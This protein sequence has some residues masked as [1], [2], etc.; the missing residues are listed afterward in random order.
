MR[1]FQLN[2]RV[3]VET[4]EHQDRLRVQLVQFYAFFVHLL[5][6]FKELLGNRANFQ[7]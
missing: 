5:D 7:L 6:L 1:Y 2:K 4:V 3:L